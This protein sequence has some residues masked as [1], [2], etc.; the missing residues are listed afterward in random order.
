VTRILV[1]LVTAMVVSLA[2]VASSPSRT[3]APAGQLGQPIRAFGAIHPRIARRGDAIVFS[4]QGAIWRLPREG[5]VM[6]RLTRGA[7]FDLEPAWSPDGKRIAFINSQNFF[8][9]ELRIV[10]AEDGSAV[11]VPAKVQAQGKLHFDPSGSRVLGSFSVPGKP[12]G[13]ALAWFDL[14]SGDVTPVTDPPQPARRSALSH[15]GKWI[16]FATHLDVPGQQS[17]NDGPQADIWRVSASGEKPEKIVRWP[18]RVYDACWSGDGESLIVTT[19]LGGAL[20]DLWQ[21][22]LADSLREARKLTYGQA[23][24]DRPSLSRDGRWLVYTDNRDG[25]TTLV[26]RDLTTGDERPVAVTHADFVAPTGRLIVRTSDSASGEPVVARLTIPQSGES[27]GKFHAPPGA[28]YRIERSNGH[29]YCRGSAELKLPAGEYV[30]RASRGPEYEVTQQKVR[31]DAEKTAELNVAMKRWVDAASLKLYSGENHI[32]ANYG[33]GEWFNTPQSMLDQCEGEDLNVCNFMVANSDTDG[34]FDRPF[35]R[36]GPDP[37]STPRT[38]LYWNQ[39][40]RATHWGHMTL[41]NLRQLVEPIFTGFKDTTNPWDVPT[42]SDIAD[43]THLQKGGLVNYTHVA[44]NAADPYVGAYTGKGM[45]VDVALGKI[46]T[47]DINNSYAGS[48]PLW[49]RLLNCGFRLP[50]SAGTDCFLNRIR[51]RLPGSD[52]AYVRINDEFSYSAWIEGLRAGRSFVTNG[53]MAEVV[54]DGRLRPGDILELAAPR[55]ATVV[56]KA[57]SQFALDKIELVYNGRVV[58]TAKPDEKGVFER[59]IMF[60]ASGWIA[61][62]AS[63]PPH[64]DSPAG[65][66]YVH[67]GPVYISVRDRPCPARADAEFFLAWIDRLAAAVRERDCILNPELKAHVESQLDAAR[68]VYRKIAER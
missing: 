4:Y 28:L 64:A 24:E 60:D 26:T 34:V 7:G 54:V 56:G 39:E 58:A 42:N 29:F 17:G 30:V 37:L 48:V 18:S 6:K 38:V 62:R 40:F 51:S 16:A 52:R 19:D 53:P 11:E 13:E 57:W 9:G 66:S 5:G 43:R 23:D 31:V 33:Y 68:A 41:V 55:E 3:R 50:A 45:P 67:T 61:L 14:K 10:N 12:G 49:Y 2:V 21:V 44:Q 25:C 46:D 15:D 47:V 36:G 65:A 1:A 8:G 32:H 59:N 35:F 20:Y 63:G 22:P 27:G